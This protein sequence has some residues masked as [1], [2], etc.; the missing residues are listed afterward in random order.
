MPALSIVRAGVQRVRP[1]AGR[2]SHNIRTNPRWA[3]GAGAVGGLGAGYMA[4]RFAQ[5]DEAYEEIRKDGTFIKMI[6]NR[7]GSANILG[8]WLLLGI[9]IGTFWYLN[10]T[11][12]S[13]DK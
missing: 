6:K 8:I 12:D 4:G 13:K 9:V 10:K 1:Y 2:L 3:L 11:K 5:P 7:D